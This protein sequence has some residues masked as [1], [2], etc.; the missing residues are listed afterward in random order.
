MRKFLDR[1]TRRAEKRWIA[2]G[3]ELSKAQERFRTL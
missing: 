3:R 1:T 2:A